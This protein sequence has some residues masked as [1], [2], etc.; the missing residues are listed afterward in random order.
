MSASLTFALRFALIS[1]LALTACSAGNG[2]S[3]AFAPGRPPSTV[4]SA[5]QSLPLTSDVTSSIARAGPGVGGFAAV[6]ASFEHSLICDNG[7]LIA[8]YAKQYGISTIFVPVSG[9]DITSL[10][11]YN[12]TTIKNLQAMIAVAN[13]YFV[14]GDPTWLDSPS[15]VPPDAASLAHIAAQH[16]KVA[17]ILYAVDPEGSSAWNSS[18]RQSL[19]ASY[20]QLVHTLLA[21]PNAAAFKQVFFVA[22]SDWST[23]HDGGPSGPTLLAH[24]Q[25]QTGV[26]GI[27]LV[28]PGGSADE[29]LAKI[30]PDL[31]LLTLPFWTEANASPYA[32]NSYHGISAA[33]LQWNLFAFQHMV[34][35]QN[36]HWL[37]SL[38]NGWTDLYNSLQSVLPQPPVFTGTLATG[39]LV[40][41]PGTT[42]LG[43]YINPNSTGTTPD[44]TAAFEMQ[45]G[46]T[47]AY[48]MHFYK[49]EAT[50]PGTGETD[51]VSKGRIP[52]I[53]WDCDD[54][55]ADVAAGKDDDTI[56]KPEARA[57]KAF[58]KTVFVRWFWEMNLDDTN[59]GNVQT[60]RSTCWDPNTD[61]PNGYFSPKYF[62]AAWRHIHQ[63]FA[64]AGVTN[65]VW[66]WCVSNA[67]G[68][69]S[70]YYPGDDVVDWV[71]TDN[72]DLTDVSMSSLYFVQ[73]E[74]LAQFQEKPLM[75]VETGAHP[76]T[77]VSFFTGAQ[78][79][80]QS[81]Y[82]QVRGIGYFDTYGRHQDW[83]LTDPAGINAFAAFANTPYMS[84]MAPSP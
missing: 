3:A 19:I 74:E 31:P 83:S 52:L 69:P 75:I 6:R 44:T 79:V 63:V 10:L 41:P 56:L 14:S 16:P 45:I 23:V 50:F 71:G 32:P 57:L 62:I 80:L 76:A 49:W 84:A 46:R 25:H 11:D 15:T 77:Q 30:G 36:P 53:A 67:H 48:N 60:A 28:A 72:Y 82:P 13:V 78:T 65:V 43:G 64:Q 26:Y 40:P 24:I 42:Y 81:Q 29:Q 37:G 38:A 21:Q 55:N 9:D 70:Q 22:D 66:L 1:L 39:R 2:S 68:G 58:G 47:L 7:I 61:L 73:L 35:E 51:D 33:L 59:N 18:Q 20:F 17:G 12:P 34:T 27:D 54:S 8:N 5:A 4:V